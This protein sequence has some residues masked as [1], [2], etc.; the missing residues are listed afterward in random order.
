MAQ[1]SVK[2]RVLF[3]GL[4]I[5]V[6]IGLFAVDIA[7]FQKVLQKQANHIYM[8][9]PEKLLGNG[10]IV[11]VLGGVLAFFGALEVT[12]L[13]R[14]KG[15]KPFDLLSALGAAL[16][17][18]QPFILPLVP[19]LNQPNLI[20]I[21]LI[22]F[23]IAQMIRRQ[24]EG[25]GANLAC[26]TFAILYLGLL[27]SYI[28]AIRAEFGPGPVILL[29]CATKGSDIGAYFTGMNFGRQKLI[30]WLSPGKTVEGFIGAVIFS[31]AITILLSKLPIITYSSVLADMRPIY[32]LFLGIGFAVTGHL[33]DLAESLLKRDAKVKDSARLLPEFG[34]ILDMVDS[35]LPAGL[36]GT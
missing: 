2:L 30:P 19:G 20:A 11:A 18:I 6:L 25:A 14:Q 23:I 29:I 15:F 12:Y 16:V 3:G 9:M 7:Y 36:Y 26:S 35:L 13:A 5:L 21:F 4:M 10:P 27:A 28:V 8:S 34:G 1:R 24:T 22:L 32:L 17:A 33:G 31:T